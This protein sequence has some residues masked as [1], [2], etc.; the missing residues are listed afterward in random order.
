MRYVKPTLCL[1]MATWLVLLGQFQIALGQTGG[2]YTIDWWTIDS[3]GGTSTGGQFAMADTVGQPDA[4]N[5]PSTDNQRYVLTDGF[6]QESVTGCVELRQLTIVGPESGQVL[7][8]YHFSLQAGPAQASI[9]LRYQWSPEPI[10][11]QGTANATYSWNTIAA[12]T[13]SASATNC[14]SLGNATDSHTINILG[15]TIGGRV[16]DGRNPIGGI[17]VQTGQGQTAVTDRNGY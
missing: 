14:N 1:I 4:A 11:G 8:T 5:F 3:G 17:T 16:T 2:P 13:I 15:R 10:S 7:D 12:Q 9:P 6:W